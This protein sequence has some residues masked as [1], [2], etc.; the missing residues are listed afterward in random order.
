MSDQMK[1]VYGPIPSRRLGQ[2]LGVD[3]VPLKT[4]NWNCIYC[5]LGRTMPLT[6]ERL[7]YVPSAE[8]L[9]QVKEALDEHEPG[10]ID[11]IS[12]VGSGEPTLHSNIGWMIREVKAMTDIPLAVITNGALLYRPEVRSDLSAADVVMPT[13]NA[14]N[15]GL[16]RRIARPHPEVTFARVAEGL[17]SFRQIFLGSLWVEIMLIKGMN[18]DVD[19]LRELATVLR[20]VQPDEVHITLPTRPP[21]ETWVEAPDEEGIMRATAILGDIAHVVHPTA[22]DVDLSGYDNVVDAVIGVITRHPLSQTQLEQALTRWV[23]EQVEAA[24]AQLAASGQARKVERLDRYF[25]TA[26]PSNFPDER[27]SQAVAPDHRHAHASPA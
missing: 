18:D 17:I 4:C 19:A 5:Q 7:A 27:Q 6:N 12:F 21:S 15:G 8:V 10:E 24:L 23:P 16:Y 9:R 11:Y 13:V 26:A 22:G 20:A 25:W 2:S 14:G 1:Y 3:V